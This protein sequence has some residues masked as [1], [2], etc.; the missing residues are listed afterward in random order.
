MINIL[1]A[2]CE[3]IAKDFQDCPIYI[4]NL[5][6]GFVRPSFYIELVNSRDIDWNATS[7]NRKM[8]FQIMYFGE[9]DDFNNVSTLEL[10]SIWDILDRSFYRSLRVSEVEYKKIT[11]N[12]LFIKDDV[13]YMTLRLEFGYSIEDNHLS[14]VELYKMMQ[15]LNMKYNYSKIKI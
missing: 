14:S 1:N 2:I 7:Q 15:E 6:Q 10:Y 11:S 12:E 13:L 3:T 8:T 9:K 5:P 4:D